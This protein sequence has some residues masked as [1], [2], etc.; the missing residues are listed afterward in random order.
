MKYV[1]AQCSFREKLVYNN[2][3]YSAAGRIMEK[4]EG[5]T[6]EQMIQERIFDPLEMTSSTTD[7]QEAI[8]SGR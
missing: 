7:L 2:L 1:P 4:I 3:M 6:W 8:D 5:K